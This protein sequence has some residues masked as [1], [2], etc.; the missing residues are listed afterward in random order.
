MFDA[1]GGTGFGALIAAALNVT[2]MM[3]KD[4]TKYMAHDLLEKL[5][6]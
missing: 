1:F 4:K 3:N 6:N 2:S 5:L